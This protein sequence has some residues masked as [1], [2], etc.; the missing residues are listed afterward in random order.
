VP[1]Q[2]RACWPG[3]T[4]RSTDV[5]P[6]LP[7]DDLQLLTIARH[8]A[9]KAAAAPEAWALHGLP[10]TEVE[11]RITA[12]EQ[13]LEERGTGRDARVKTRAEIDAA[14]ARAKAALDVLDVTVAN[15]VAT[16]PVVL[17]VWKHDRR[18][19][20][21]ARGRRLNGPPEPEPAPASTPEPAADQ[22]PA[23]TLV[24]PPAAA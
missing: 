8:L 21:P 12:F 3:P 7:G 11:A 13:A 22:P 24:T 5:G 15:C 2:P 14:L 18:I 16:D 20:Y 9:E 1:A 23:L 17:A 4:R 19:V 10:V 6:R